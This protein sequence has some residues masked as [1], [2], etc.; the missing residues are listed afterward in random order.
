MITKNTDEAPEELMRYYDLRQLPNGVIFFDYENIYWRLQEYGKNII[1]LN[2]IES[3]K[4]FFDE[5]RINI[6]DFMIYANFDEKQFHNS[7]HQTYL[8]GLGVTTKH[9]SNKGKNASDIQLVVDALKVLYKND[10]VDVFIIVSSDRDMSPLIQAVKQESKLAY[11]ITTKI[12]FEKGMINTA[13][14][15]EYLENILNLSLDYKQADPAIKAEDISAQDVEASRDVMALL[16]SSRIWERFI[17]RGNPINFNEF[18]K[19]IA[20]AKKM[21]QIEVDRLFKIA[22]TKQWIQLYKFKRNGVDVT[23]IKGGEKLDEVITSGIFKEQ[24]M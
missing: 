24:F 10:L 23:G 6:L 8:Q 19:H 11:L 14:Y 13:D 5:K 17:K 20:K 22:Q 18:K 9:T 12:G 3:V 15:H 2:L 21:L 1:E 7:F 16:L 4:N